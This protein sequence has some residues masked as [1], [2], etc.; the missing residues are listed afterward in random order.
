MD[1]HSIADAMDRAAA[2]LAVAAEEVH[3]GYDP[4]NPLRDVRWLGLGGA[5]ARRRARSHLAHWSGY[6]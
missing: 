1:S 6:V 5:E 2:L 4:Y 3:V